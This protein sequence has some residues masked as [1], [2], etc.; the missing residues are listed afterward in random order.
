[1]PNNFDAP[2][3]RALSDAIR[4]GGKEVRSSTRKRLKPAG[5]IIAVEIRSRAPVGATGKLS[6]RIYARAGQTSV[7]VVSTA[8]ARN[9]YQYGRRLEFDPRYGYVRGV[10][11]SS[12]YA[13]FYPGFTAKKEEAL[14]ELRRILDD[15]AREIMK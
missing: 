9:R 5:E 1:M 2:G 11:G 8:V 7:R 10:E 6:S 13:F 12:R 4:N 15:V 14:K 3:A